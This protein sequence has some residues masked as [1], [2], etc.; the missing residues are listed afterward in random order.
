MDKFVKFSGFANANSA[1][2]QWYGVKKKVLGM[3]SEDGLTLPTATS[4]PR[5]RKPKAATGNEEEAAEGITPTKKL[6]TPTKAKAPA[7]V[8]DEDKEKPE[9]TDSVGGEEDEKET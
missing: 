8:K 5:K 6:K 4:T 2:V 9:M 3:A 1:R 7:P